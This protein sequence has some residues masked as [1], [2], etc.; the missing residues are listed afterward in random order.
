MAQHT[1]S[2][3]NCTE[4]ASGRN[5]FCIKDWF[6]MPDSHRRLIR[7]DTGKGE[8][9]LRAHPTNEWMSRALSYLGS[10]R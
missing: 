8:H 6:S 4:L 2:N 5:L 1:C 7:H 3:P 10:K 9:S